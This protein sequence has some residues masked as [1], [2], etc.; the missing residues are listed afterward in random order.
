M[1]LVPT[2]THD[3]GGAP[4]PHSCSKCFGKQL[5][6]VT[7]H[8]LLLL[9]SGHCITQRGNL[10][11]YT[12]PFI[13]GPGSKWLTDFSRV[14]GWASLRWD[15]SVLWF[16]LIAPCGV[17]PRQSFTWECILAWII[18]LPLAVPLTPLQVSPKSMPLRN[19]THLNPCFRFCFYAAQPKTMFQFLSII[20]KVTIKVLCSGRPSNY[21]QKRCYLQSRKRAS[22]YL[23]A[24]PSWQTF[25]AIYL[26][27]TLPFILMERTLV[28]FRLETCPLTGVHLPQAPCS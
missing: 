25:L 26:F 27:F 12:G 9:A 11:G 22:I 21:K 8:G 18:S 16:R 3:R 20:L 28:L 15:K 19:H 1:L 24:W 13:T 10:G 23:P 2:Q 17:K 6:P 7:L 4:L 5:T 14:K